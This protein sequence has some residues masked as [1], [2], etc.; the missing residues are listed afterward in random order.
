MQLHPGDKVGLV[1]CS[2]GHPPQRKETN[3]ALHRVL[4]SFGLVPI[5][6][7]LIYA[8]KSVFSGSGKERAEIVNAFY[9][10]PDIRAIF[11]LSGGNVGNQVLEYLDYDLIRANPKPFVGYSDLTTILNGIYTKTGNSG[12]LYQLRNLVGDSGSL[13]QHRFLQTW[14]YGKEDLTQHTFTFLKGNSMSGVVVGGNLRCLL[15]LAGTPYFPDCTD[16]ILFLESLGGGPGEITA[17]AVQ[18]RQM[19]VFSKIQGLLLG[20][21][22]KLE[23]S[24]DRC[25]AAELF[26]PIVEPYSFSVAR[27]KEIGH[28]PD[29]KAI[30]I[31]KPITVINKGGRQP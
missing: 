16:K 17:M 13:Q 8:K 9:R 10:N 18:L 30:W 20:T 5:W 12:C 29:S 11:D 25:S 24:E 27:T 21:F 6:S 3:T 22:S 4:E 19:G 2:D 15:K 31:G 7:P 14:F 23:S 26:L 28:G 1:C